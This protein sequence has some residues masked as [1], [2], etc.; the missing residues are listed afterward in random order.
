LAAWLHGDPHPDDAIKFNT[1]V[2][3]IKAGMEA[4]EA[5]KQGLNITN[6]LLDYAYST[7]APAL[8]P[9]AARW[10]Q[11]NK[12]KQKNAGTL[13]SSL[14]TPRALHTSLNLCLY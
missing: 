11:K 1:D 13:N 12:Y 8:C 14:L 10:V 7:F 2:E 4:S 9:A 3:G 6:G 5:F